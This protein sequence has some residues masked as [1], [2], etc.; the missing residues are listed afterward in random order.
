MNF[1]FKDYS[2]KDRIRV[3]VAIP[4]IGI[5]LMGG[6]LVF[7]R[8][9]Q[10]GQ[11]GKLIELIQL[12]P[13]ISNVAH[14][15]QVERGMSAGYVV[16]KK[17]RFADTLPSQR[18]KTDQKRKQLNEA[19][20]SFDAA[21]FSMALKNKISILKKNISV[22]DQTRREIDELSIKI[23]DLAKSYT[24]LIQNLL[25]SVEEMVAVGS[26]SGSGLISQ[27]GAY[28][29]V[30]QM[31]EQAGL[32]RGMGSIGFGAYKFS[33]DVYRQFVG[34]IAGQRTYHSTFS[35]FATLKQKEFYEQTMRGT[36]I[37]EVDR[38]RNIA[39]MSPESGT[40]GGIQE[41]IWFEAISSKIDLLKR[42]ENHL[43]ADVARTINSIHDDALYQLVEL[44][45]V[46]TVLL[47][48]VGGLSS[49]VVLGIS[50][51]ISEMTGQMNR[52]A[53]G[54]L[55]TPITGTERVDEI[56]EMAKAVEVF[57]GN[58]IETQS[59]ISSIAA[60]LDE[61]M[62]AVN[63]QAIGTTEQASSVTQMATSLQ[64][65]NQT[66]VQT[67]HKAGEL[68]ETAE[69]TQNE[70]MEGLGRVERSVDAIHST[71]DRVESISNSILVLSEHNKRI[72]EITKVVGSLSQ[73]SKMLAINASIEASKAGDAGKGFAV[74]A[75]EVS[76]LAEQSEEA[77]I[78]V[79][80]ILEEIENST[81]G[82][83]MATEEG[84]KQVNRGVELVQQAGKAIE[85]LNSVI[86]E[87]SMASQQI[88]ASLRDQT[89]G[90]AQ[91]SISV[92]EISKVTR[93]FVTSAELIKSSMEGL[94]HQVRTLRQN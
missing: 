88:L 39:L 10:F 34:F 17:R 61:V 28:T 44:F 63:V 46:L 9:Q 40:T 7:E 93:Q 77:T 24:L 54:Q 21:K 11:S 85:S 15:L 8:V 76:N 74:V 92:D 48:V 83:V 13:I 26:D 4:V 37:D 78:Q 3:L 84:S 90:I 27:I 91:V 5:L 25:H 55:D 30:L 58:A 29:A 69:R 45:L 64:E 52:L 33:P 20:K 72:G 82:V 32:E 51:P 79:S 57:K 60:A 75:E 94:S 66:T 67:M 41:T 87:T 42:I 14:E 19:F 89:Q 80:K 2:I 71:H 36:I 22:L 6:I 38:L 18:Q 1:N 35:V 43:E 23:P 81:N 86:G 62:E 65:I 56:G 31:N 68:N 70:G 16:S 50:G 59:L 49:F 73:Q 47:V 53:E 12:A